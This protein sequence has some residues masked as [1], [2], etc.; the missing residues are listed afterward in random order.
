MKLE[1]GTYQL[2]I[3]MTYDVKDGKANPIHK[4]M[5]YHD[6]EPGT[7][8]AV[9]V[10]NSNVQYVEGNNQSCSPM[11]AV[12]FVRSLRLR[13]DCDT[14]IPKLEFVFPDL[15]DP[16][17]DDTPNRGQYVGF[18]TTSTDDQIQRLSAIPGIDVIVN[19]LD[20]SAPIVLVQEIGT[21]GYIDSIPMKKR[22]QNDL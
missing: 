20:S 16:N 9:S 3:I 18:L 19:R 13:A 21:D 14:I 1:D 10:E 11:N 4:T 8:H 12:G 17:I 2:K 22:W 7:N 6:I 5:I 15:H